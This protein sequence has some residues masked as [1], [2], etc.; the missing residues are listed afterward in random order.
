VREPN[1]FHDE[2][3]HI[4]G[5][6]LVPLATVAAAARRWRTDETIVVVC[7]S[8]R[9]SEQAARMLVLAGFDRVMNMVGG[10]LAWNAA[11]LPVAARTLDASTR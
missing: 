10:M 3:A 1:E 2:L 8:G 11:G 9:R 7:R 5:A 4:E 6:E